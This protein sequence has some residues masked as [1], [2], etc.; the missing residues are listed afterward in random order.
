MNIELTELKKIIQEEIENRF[1]GNTI[2]SSLLEGPGSTT[3]TYCG[4]SFQVPNADTQGNV[5]TEDVKL[6]YISEMQDFLDSFL[7]SSKQETIR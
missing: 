3:K 6:L 7:N 1:G 4:V 2:H 5:L